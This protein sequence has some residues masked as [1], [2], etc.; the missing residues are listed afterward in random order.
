MSNLPNQSELQREA[1]FYNLM[2][3]SVQIGNLEILTMLKNLNNS[4]EVAQAIR[5]IDHLLLNLSFYIKQRQQNYPDYVVDENIARESFIKTRE[6]LANCKRDLFVEELKQ[7]TNTKNFN[8]DE[9][10]ENMIKMLFSRI[11]QDSH[12]DREDDNMMSYLLSKI[13]DDIESKIATEADTY[14]AAAESLAPQ[15]SSVYDKPEFLDLPDIAESYKTTPKFAEENYTLHARQLEAAENNLRQLAE[16]GK[17][18]ANIDIVETPLRNESDMASR[19]SLLKSLQYRRANEHRLLLSEL[20]VLLAIVSE[21]KL[22]T[23]LIHIPK[24]VINVFTTQE[25]SIYKNIMAKCYSVVVSSYHTEQINMAVN[26]LETYAAN[27]CALNND[28][29]EVQAELLLE[30]HQA[31]LETRHSPAHMLDGEEIYTNHY[32]NNL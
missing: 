3:D 10:G 7:A 22:G 8:Q 12:N 30:C 14:R 25:L 15:S 6:L 26:N 19:A 27:I 11:E 2:F 23:A 28:I 18:T 1:A 21:Y 31:I 24:D 29:N 5:Y 20:N 4:K 9:E 13:S 17:I 16:A 32:F